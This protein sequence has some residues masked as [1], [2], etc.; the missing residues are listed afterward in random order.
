MYTCT[1]L[2]SCACTGRWTTFPPDPQAFVNYDGLALLVVTFR[3]RICI[4]CKCIFTR[5]C[6]YTGI[7]RHFCAYTH[8]HIGLYCLRYVACSN[9][10][11]LASNCYKLYPSERA[12]VLLESASARAARVR[13]CACCS[14]PRVRVLLES[15]SARAA[16]VRECACCSSPRVL[17]LHESASARAARVRECACCSSPRVPVLLESASARAAHALVSCNTRGAAIQ[18]LLV[19][20]AMVDWPASCL[21]ACA[22]SRPGSPCRNVLAFNTIVS[23]LRLLKYLHRI[24]FMVRNG[25]SHVCVLAIQRRPVESFAVLHMHRRCILRLSMA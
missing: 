18:Q 15:A 5:M 7:E 23:Y 16:R 19:A 3:Y 11:H 9:F 17:V 20:M 12:P 24:P 13:E 8:V 25:S 10:R 21:I 22:S 4:M 6:S 1:Y 14:S 2:N